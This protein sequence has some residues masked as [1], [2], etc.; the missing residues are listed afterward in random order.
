MA[1]EAGAGISPPLRIPGCL[2]RGSLLPVRG[3]Y[4]KGRQE[5]GGNRSL[6]LVPAVAALAAGTSHPFT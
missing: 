6:I 1:V 3:R 2:L 5:Y 4:R